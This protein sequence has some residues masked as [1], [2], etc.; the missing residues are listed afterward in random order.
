MFVMGKKY[1]LRVIG[2]L[3]ECGKGGGGSGIIEMNQYVI[4]NEGHR[5][6]GLDVSRQAPEPQG[7]KK[8]IAASVA[9]LIQG[10]E[11]AVR[12]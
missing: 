12:A 8:L 5:T 2:Q 6:I 7:K 4:D 9:H 1:H 10:Q 3:A 11:P